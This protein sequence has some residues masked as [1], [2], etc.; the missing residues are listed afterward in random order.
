M[1][2]QQAAQTYSQTAWPPHHLLN[3]DHMYGFHANDS[4]PYLQMA[5]TVGNN[6]RILDMGCGTGFLSFAFAR[7]V[8]ASCSIIGVDI[9][10]GLLHLAQNKMGAGAPNGNV[11]FRNADITSL[12]SLRG[13]LGDTKF[14]LIVAAWVI[15][16]L[17]NAEATVSM[18]AQNFLR[19]GGA[20]VFD[21]AHPTDETDV[22][23]IWEVPG[24]LAAA[25]GP[26]QLLHHFAPD[27]PHEPRL[28]S[29]ISIADPDIHTE[30]KIE[31]V[32]FARQAGLL[33]D[34]HPI[35]AFPSCANRQDWARA[36]AQA[37][38][39][40]IPAANATW[41]EAEDTRLRALGMNTNVC[42]YKYGS[43]T[44]AYVAR[45]IVGEPVGNKKPCP[46][47]SG[48]KWKHCHKLFV[49]PVAQPELD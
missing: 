4:V 7:T 2:P 26:Q 23:S 3:Y 46:C 30:C 38:G 34:A 29:N 24:N 8:P 35:N 11:Q 32:R 49:Q 15:H 33:L 31:A 9:C 20:L 17:P 25:A 27:P 12:N 16:M 18:W 44:A 6:Q 28:P 47:G 1:T 19:P 42:N 37:M 14:D 41:A 45:F 5:E 36:N 43:K 39:R 21:V 13:A 10:Q 40:T 48:S 22:F